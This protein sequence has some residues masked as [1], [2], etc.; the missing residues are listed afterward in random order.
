MKCC[1]SCMSV[2]ARS[3]FHRF[4]S[5]TTMTADLQKAEKAMKAL[6]S[7]LDEQVGE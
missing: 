4:A 7:Q 5:P 3:L 1:L 6:R 2:K